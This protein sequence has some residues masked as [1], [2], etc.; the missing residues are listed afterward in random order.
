MMQ[1]LTSIKAVSARPTPNCALALPLLRQSEHPPPPSCFISLVQY[2]WKKYT[3]AV[4]F[5]SF[6]GHPGQYQE[7]ASKISASHQERAGDP[8]KRQRSQSLWS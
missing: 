8:G 5:S 4:R 1:H 7:Q 2:N 6:A 3:E